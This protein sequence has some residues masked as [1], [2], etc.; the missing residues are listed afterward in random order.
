M[1]K[2]EQ[3]LILMPMLY[4]VGALGVTWLV[5]RGGEPPL[6]FHPVAWYGTLIARL[7]RRTPAEAS[8][9]MFFGVAML[10]GATALVLPPII[11][12]D[13]LIAQLQKGETDVWS[14]ARRLLAMLLEGV[15][16]KPF[17]SLHMLV[18][19]GKTVRLALERGELET[20]RQ[21]LRSLVSRDRAGL[22]QDLIVAAT[23]ESLAENVS[24]SVVAPLFYYALFGLPGAA[25]YRLYNTFDAMI[26]YH[27]RYEYVGK[28]AARLDDVLNLLPS[29]LTALLIVCCAPF[30]AGDYRR[31]W[32]IWRRD[33]HKTESPNAG[34][35]MAACAG[36]LSVQLEKVGAYILGDALYPLESAKIKQ[37][38]RMTLCIGTIAFVLAACLR[39]AWKLQRSL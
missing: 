18:D 22:D 25:L 13:C 34:Q 10:I 14:T 8:A 35:P 28:A 4:G 32:S 31:A 20:A 39:A 5:D 2:K 30:Y 21:A 38:E 23:I 37:A 27:G 3:P 15:C 36:A 19:A 11:L 6:R 9:Q 26:G 17:L 33:A 7:Q 29:R 1:V 24:D 16:L 12:I